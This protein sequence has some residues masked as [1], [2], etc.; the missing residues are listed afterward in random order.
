MPVTLPVSLLSLLASLENHLTHLLNDDDVFTVVDYEHPYFSVFS[1]LKEEPLYKDVVCPL[2]IHYSQFHQTMVGL[3]RNDTQHAK[4]SLLAFFEQELSE[5][6]CQHVSILYIS[7]IL[8]KH[9]A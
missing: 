2:Y 6:T 8:Y 4:L 3:S 7:L 1:Q 5:M 9:Y